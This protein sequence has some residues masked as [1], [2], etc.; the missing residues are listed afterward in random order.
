MV[1]PST[2]LDTDDLVRD[3]ESGV[4]A[5]KLAE[6]HGVGIRTIQNSLARMGAHVRRLAEAN[7]LRAPQCA[8]LDTDA[9]VRDY[10][11]GV[12]LKALSRKHGVSRCAI[13]Q[14]LERRGVSI[15]GRS[16]ANRLIWKDRA[17]N[18]SLIER[19]CAKAWAG[20]RGRKN[21]LAWKLAHA[22]AGTCRRIGAFELE[23]KSAIEALGVAVSHQHPVYVY[24]LD[25]ALTEFAVA[26]EV[27]LFGHKRSMP[28]HR[29]I[30]ILDRG[31][32]LLI[33]HRAIGD[34][35]PIDVDAVAQKVVAFAKATNLAP[36]VRR[37]YGV[38]GR[39]ANPFATRCYDFTDCPRVPG[40]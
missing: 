20:R 32:S 40:F 5:Q 12:S 37:Q 14:R 1:R 7:G 8:V 34:R 13:G 18:R 30:D 26:V 23:I 9:L 25:L 4:T 21:T 38:I 22:E 31:W 2:F 6:K 17:G 36:A 10:E 24:N 35:T 11:A 27:C 16:S 19:Q 15:R 33:V 39:D 29:I 3:Y 28:R